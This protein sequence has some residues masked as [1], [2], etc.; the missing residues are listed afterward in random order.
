MGS[1]EAGPSLVLKDCAD[2]EAI[3]YSGGQLCFSAGTCVT[4]DASA[5]RRRLES[6]TTCKQLTL[7]AADAAVTFSALRLDDA[8]VWRDADGQWL[9]I[10]DGAIYACDALD[11]AGMINQVPGGIVYD[12]GDGGGGG[13]G[14]GGGGGNGDGGGGGN[15]DGGGMGTGAL[16][17]AI[18]GGVTVVGGTAA[19]AYAKLGRKA[20]GKVAQAV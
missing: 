10:V 13:N 17:G 11:A 2:S 4:V 6:G 14:D 9:Q 3:E 12:G 20:D 7:G 15:G 8:D 19:L 1:G 18:A 16:I 5:S